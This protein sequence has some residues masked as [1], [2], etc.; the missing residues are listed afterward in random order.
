MSGFI[1]MGEGRKEG[2]ENRGT[3][4]ISLQLAFKE[5][6]A[7]ATPGSEWLLLSLVIGYF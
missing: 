5:R 6:I 7:P 2:K 1:T 4:A 3:A